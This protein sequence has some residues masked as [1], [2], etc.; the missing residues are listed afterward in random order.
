MPAK[1]FFISWI[2]SSVVMF[3]ISY[4]WHGLFLTDFSRISYPKGLFLTFAVIVYLIFGFVIVKA[5]EMD[6]MANYFKRKPILKGAFVGAVLGFIFFLIS[7]VVG[8]SFST[9]SNLKNLLLDVCWQIIE[10]GVGGVTVG[11]V[12]ILFYYTTGPIE[13]ET[14]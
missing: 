11:V 7:T 6:L 2:S 10:Q 14:Y 8:V 13:E 12:Y 1:R 5:V 3:L 4:V 9:G